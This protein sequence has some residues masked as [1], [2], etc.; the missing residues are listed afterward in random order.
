MA[1]AVAAVVLEVPLGGA[2]VAA[3]VS[4]VFEVAHVKARL[5]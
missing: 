3:V 1:A 2:V 5:E 4:E